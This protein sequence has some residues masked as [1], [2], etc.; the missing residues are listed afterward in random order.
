[1]DTTHTGVEEN[2]YGRHD[3]VGND[4]QDASFNPISCFSL[5]AADPFTDAG[6]GKRSW[7]SMEETRCLKV[8]CFIRHSKAA[9]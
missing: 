3:E 6:V 5:C 2:E 7:R 1:M 9:W 4:K 8:N